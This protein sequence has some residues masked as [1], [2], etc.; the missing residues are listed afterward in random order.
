MTRD[1]FRQQMELYRQAREQNPQLSYWGWKSLLREI[2]D[3]ANQSDVNFVDRL[4]QFNRQTIPDWSGEGDV[5]THRMSWAEDENGNAIVYPEVQEIN[6]K[7]HDFTDPRYN[8]GKWDALD[9]AIER[10][11]TIHMTPFEAQQFTGGYKNFYPKFN[12]GTNKEGIQSN[13]FEYKDIPMATKMR[14]QKGLSQPELT[15]EQQIVQNEIQQ[16]RDW[17]NTWLR[18]RKQTGRFDDQLTDDY[19]QFASNR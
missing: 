13:N 7:L 6:G 14:Q 18:K 19:L 15:D 11:D 2:V 16:A 4:N 5:A 1:E 10:G 9:S 3:K 8:H 17:N 12:E